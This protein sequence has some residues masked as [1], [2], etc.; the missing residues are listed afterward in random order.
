MRRVLILCLV[1]APLFG[2][3]FLIR[4]GILT[5]ARWLVAGLVVTPLA[6]Y[7]TFKKP[8]TR[9]SSRSGR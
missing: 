1:A 4:A 5:D 2:S 8:A 3:V 9:G 7:L 6:A